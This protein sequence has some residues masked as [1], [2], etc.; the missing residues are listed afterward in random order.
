KQ[1]LQLLTPRQRDWMLSGDEHG[2]E[3]TV[4]AAGQRDQAVSRL[5]EPGYFDVRPF[6]RRGLKVGA[7]TQPHQAAVAAFVGREQNQARPIMF[8]TA[9]FDITKIDRDRASYDRLNSGARQLFREF[10]RAEHVV[11]I[12]QGECWL[13]I[14]PGK[15]G[16]PRNR[17]CAFEQRV[18][19]MNVQMHESRLSWHQ[20]ASVGSSSCFSEINE[21]RVIRTAIAILARSTM[22]DWKRHCPSSRTRCGDRQRVFPQY[23]PGFAGCRYKPSAAACTRPRY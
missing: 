12:G 4:G 11:G 3:R 13:P 18:G 15:F 1:P 2:V 8:G 20:M 7:G 22:R 14:V 16:Q 10:Q 19:R 6:L 9:V 21:W 5:V 17:Q 23:A